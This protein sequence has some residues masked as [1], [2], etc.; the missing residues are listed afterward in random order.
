MVDADS[1]FSSSSTSKSAKKRQ[2]TTA[3]KNAEPVSEKRVSASL[4]A[5]NGITQK[6]LHD[7]FEN[8]PTNQS[9]SESSSSESCSDIFRGDSSIRNDVRNRR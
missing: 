6:I 1:G 5:V 8:V 7:S 4:L 3:K 2:A 9:L